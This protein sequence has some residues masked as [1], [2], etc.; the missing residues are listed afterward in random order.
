LLE[1]G[2]GGPRHTLVRFQFGKRRKINRTFDSVDKKT[3]MLGNAKLLLFSVKEYVDG[4]LNEVKTY[5]DEFYT[6]DVL[7]LIDKAK[8][9]KI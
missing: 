8:S 9:I 3:G 5:T 4:L 2:K 6:N 1:E 7:A